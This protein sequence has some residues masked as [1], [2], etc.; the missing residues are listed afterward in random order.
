[1]NSLWDIRIFLRLVPKESLC[2][3]YISYHTNI[4][5]RA[6]LLCYE[7]RPDYHSP[8][9]PRP[10]LLPDIHNVVNH[11]ARRTHTQ[12]A[13][14]VNQWVQ[15][16]SGRECGRCEMRICCGRRRQAVE[17]L[18]VS[19][20]HWRQEG[21]AQLSLV[22]SKISMAGIPSSDTDSRSTRV[23]RI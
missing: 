16:A 14:Q 10:P 23:R 17:L 9:F 4:S 8:G 11:H 7:P 5:I 3:S 2:I 12:Q 20:S 18:A 13:M 1:M 6:W 21:W 19:L 22:L 15:R